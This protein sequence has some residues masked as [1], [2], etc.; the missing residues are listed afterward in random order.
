VLG[1]LR[2]T[3]QMTANLGKQKSALQLMRFSVMVAVVTTAIAVTMLV[4]ALLLM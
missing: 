4:L 3:R 2:P 1:L